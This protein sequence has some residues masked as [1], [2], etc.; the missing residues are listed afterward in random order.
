MKETKIKYKCPECGEDIKRTRTEVDDS[1]QFGGF[2]FVT[3]YGYC[4]NCGKIDITE[5]YKL[6]RI[7]R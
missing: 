5:Q 4:M 2:C 6:G 1:T 3:L 7:V